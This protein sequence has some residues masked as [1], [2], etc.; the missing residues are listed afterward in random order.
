[1]LFPQRNNLSSFFLSGT[2]VMSEKLKETHQ[3]RK[4]DS[5]VSIAPIRTLLI[6]D[7]HQDARVIGAF[8]SA[9]RSFAFELCWKT[10]L[11][12]GL[13]RLEHE[14]FDVVILD[15]NLPGSSGI[16]T[17]SRTYAKAP[18]V[19]I[20]IL[21]GEAQ[22]DTA[23]SA[24][25]QGAQD[26]LLKGEID[27]KALVRSLTFA[28]ERHARKAAEA[29]LLAKEEELQVTRLREAFVQVASHELRTPLAI[30]VGMTKLATRLGDVDDPLRSWLVTISRATKRLEQAVD[31]MIAL[32]L[33]NRHQEQLSLERTDVGEFLRKAVADA[34]FF[35]ES[36]QQRLSLSIENDLGKLEIDRA[37]IHNCLDHLLFNAIK[38][39]PDGGH[40]EVAAKRDENEIAIRVSDTG[41]GIDEASLPHIFDAFFTGFDISHHSS[42]KFEYQSKGLGLGL[43]TARLFVGMHGGS[44]DV[45]S[46]PGRGSIFTIH[47]PI[48][49]VLNS[50][51]EPDAV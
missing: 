5:F 38:F 46:E 26:F 24:L 40:I 20:V 25:E 49:T 16:E 15:L 9:S 2:N 31:Q 39:T 19:P 37:K 8:L 7:N 35:V 11:Q 27:Q 34:W 41:M 14:E 43:T 50:A 44:I 12:Q 21:T 28:I 6:E 32:V 4:K 47:L 10:Q 3:R 30:I 29:T 36:R 18:H 51:E 33:E 17:F 48:L 13:A 42:G 23:T 1:M 45:S 22:I